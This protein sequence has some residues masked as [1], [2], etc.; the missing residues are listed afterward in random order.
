MFTGIVEAMGTVTKLEDRPGF[1]KLWLSGPPWLIN[2]PS[3]GSLS[4]NGCCTT[5]IGAGDFACDL[6]K[7]TLE[8]TSLGLLEHGSRVNLERP[9]TLGAELGGHLVQGHVDG[10]GEVASIETI[11]D[12][13]LIEIR[14]PAELRRYVVLTGSI[15]V[16]GVS[17]TVAEINEQSI[18]IG[19]IP[20]TWN[21]TNFQDY[22]PGRRVNIEVDLIGKYIER[23]LPEKLLKGDLFQGLTH[24]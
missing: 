10:T 23:P 1:R 3:G 2:Y 11:G 22:Y 9:L 5:N 15:A 18:V 6:M 13:R 24:E 19:I 8:K 14:I 12:T 17:L 16:D 7:V 21:V 4:I 20:H